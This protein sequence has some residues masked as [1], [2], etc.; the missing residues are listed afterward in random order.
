[1]YRD[2]L[3]PDAELLERGEQG[4]RKKIAVQGPALD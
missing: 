3:D 1:V 2:R 4:Y